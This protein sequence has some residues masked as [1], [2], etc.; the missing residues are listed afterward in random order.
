MIRQLKDFIEIDD[1][2]V[3]GTNCITAL[4]TTLDDTYNPYLKQILNTDKDSLSLDYL[5]NRLDKILSPLYS[6]LIDKY[7][8]DGDT[9][10]E[11]IQHANAKLIKIIESKYLYNWNR[12]AEA[13]F[14]DYNPINN[15]DM[16]ETR[17]VKEQTDRSVITEGQ[18]DVVDSTESST[19][20]TNT[21][22]VSESGQK[23]ASVS[24]SGSVEESTE[25][26]VNEENNTISNNSTNEVKD[27]SGSTRTT[28]EGEIITNDVEQQKYAGFNT[29]T[30]KIVTETSKNGDTTE[31][32]SGTSSE[33]HSGTNTTTTSGSVT[34]TKE[35]S[36]T[37][38]KEGTTSRSEES[39]ESNETTGRQTE[40]KSG[41]GS[42]T[43]SGSATS[44]ST[45]ETEGMLED[46]RREE[47]LRRSGNIG[48]T[49]SQQM[50]QSE[51][52]LRKHNLE[53]IIFNNMDE[54]LFL[55]Y[56]L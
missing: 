7:I 46:N 49:T 21:A 47:E 10:D 43:H 48:V 31:T 33:V 27:E 15:Y 23:T 53:D 22:S 56:Y 17:E 1:I 26:E 13:M 37:V 38:T 55:D 2:L 24:E 16:V 29:D 30:P 40:S 41:T 45:T 50:I 25:A 35:G 19:S 3:N 12:L 52:E 20:E 54:V 42:E 11:A 51:I 28:T 9:D 36:N 6:R 18:N 8:A 32:H 14:K 4:F 5:G 34:E 44:T 39:S